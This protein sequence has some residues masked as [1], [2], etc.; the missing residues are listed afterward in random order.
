VEVCKSPL[1]CGY[2]AVGE[3]EP[4]LGFL[5]LLDTAGL[6]NDERDLLSE[7]SWWSLDVRAPHAFSARDVVLDDGQLGV[8]SEYVEGEPLR[9]VL[10][11]SAFKKQPAT[12]PVALA[13]VQD[14]ARGVRA[15]EAQAEPASGGGAGTAANG[16]VSSDHVHVG[17]DGVARLSD[18]G[19]LSAARR[20]PR[21]QHLTELAQ[22]AAPELHRGERADTKSD[23]F[24]IG[25]IFWELL[26]G[27]KHLFIGGSASVLAERITGRDAPRLEQGALAKLPPQV[28]EVTARA[29]RREPNERYA[30]LDELLTALEGLGERAT[31][32]TV[33]KWVAG[34]ASTAFTLRAK[35]IEK[36][37]AALG[38]TP[39]TK[40][41][42]APLDGTSKQSAPKASVVAPLPA[43]APKP[44]VKPPAPASIAPPPLTA[45]ATRPTFESVSDDVLEELEPESEVDSLEMEVLEPESEVDS[46]EMEALEP[47]LDNDAPEGETAPAPLQ[48]TA[49]RRPIADIDPIGTSVPPPPF[50]ESPLAGFGR[51]TRLALAGAALTLALS[52]AWCASRPEKTQQ[53]EAA[54]AEA[55]K[56]PSAAKTQAPTPQPTS[57][58]AAKAEATTAEAPSPAPAPEAPPA[59]EPAPPPKTPANVA[60]RPTTS[61]TRSTTAPATKSAT[62]STAAKSLTTK[63]ASTK[64]TTTKASSTNTKSATTK[65]P[66]A[67]TA[68]TKRTTKARTF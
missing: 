41:P 7:G 45:S 61:A 23:V 36:A 55:P 68:S 34:L 17:T 59:A 44:S 52:A 56:A 16:N 47:A 14:I 9:N 15:L 3:E 24:S 21:F 10:R 43:P 38:S 51:S 29:L 58:A 63:T 50:R 8:V 65:K 32:E 27:G 46:L 4:R 20:V 25:V 67:T 12:L 28:S 48:R 6:S 11:L 33:G 19:V 42:S 53:P 37:L 2:I 13:L 64:S 60:A 1:G 39:T 30:D 66:A 26:S 35:Q 54:V 31:P 40:A 18:P 57:I 49:T 62:K 22:Y 5:R